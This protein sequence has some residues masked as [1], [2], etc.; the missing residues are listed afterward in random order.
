M[1]PEGSQ[2][3]TS[4]FLLWDKIDQAKVY[5]VS[6]NGQQTEET[7]GTY[8]TIQGLTPGTTYQFTVSA[9][10]ENGKVITKKEALT[11]ITKPT[12][13]I[14]N[15]QDY[16][17]E[18]GEGQLNTTAIQAAIDACPQGGTVLIPSGLYYSGALFLKSN[19]TLY[20]EE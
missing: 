4:V 5:R 18:S 12:P 6:Y 2:T 1:A 13:Q 10:G 14:L 3:D 8:T 17:A 7:T 9:L 11:V 19:M 20:L 15:I 16:G